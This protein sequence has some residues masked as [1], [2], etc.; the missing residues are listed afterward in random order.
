MMVK[1]LLQKIWEILLTVTLEAQW[2]SLQTLYIPEHWLR[3]EIAKIK[4]TPIWL[5]MAFRS[6]SQNMEINIL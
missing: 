6:S 4:E 2:V 3:E 5:T 1:L